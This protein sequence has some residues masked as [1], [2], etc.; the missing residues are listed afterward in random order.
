[1]T[2]SSDFIPEQW[3]GLDQAPLSCT[4]KI[5]ILNE[6]LREIR[7]LAQEALEDGVLMGADPDQVRAVLARSVQDLPE[8]FS[9]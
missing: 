9:D 3:L 2:G 6:N 8:P 7:D 5:K 1:M 4:E